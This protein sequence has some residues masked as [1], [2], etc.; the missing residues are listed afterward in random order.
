MSLEHGSVTLRRYYMQSSCKASSDP[1]WVSS[2]NENAFIEKTLGPDEDNTGWSV[3]GNELSTEFSIDNTAFGK[4]ILISFRRDSVK[5]QRTMLNLLLKSRIHERLKSEEIETIS[6]KQKAEIKEEIL[7][8]LTKKTSPNLQIIQALVDTARGEVFL[9]STSDKIC[10][11]F[12]MLFSQTF[13][14]QLLEANFMATAQRNLSEEVFEN[15]LDAPGILLGPAFD[16]H[17]DFEDTSEGKLGS[18]FLTW[19]LYQLQTGDG[20]WASKSL[21]EFGMIL[22]DYL[23]LEGE[24]LGSKQMLLKKGVLGRCAELATSLKVGKL[25]SKIRCQLARDTLAPAE[26][27]AAGSSSEPEEWS[28]VVDKI[29]YDLSSLKMPKYSD[30]NEAAR[31]LGRMGYIVEAFEIMDELFSSFLELRYSKEWKKHH[32][33]MTN[34]V[35]ELQSGE[36]SNPS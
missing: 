18:S 28:F 8:E 35:I 33:A 32:E 1:N 24:A 7:D 2:L 31:T 6:Q 36:W 27:D 29:N 26:G 10:E 14:I 21:G 34:W 30:G 13:S 15:V 12:L 19:L 5:I 4:F 20:T 9:S 16:V 23:L 22:N 11:S 17:P 25:V 3:F